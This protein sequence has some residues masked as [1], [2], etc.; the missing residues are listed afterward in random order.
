MPDGTNFLMTAFAYGTNEDYLVHVIAVLRIIKKKGMASDIKVTW[1][2]MV[3]VR[4]EMKPYFL[5]PEDE[6][7]AAKE[8]W[9]QMLSEYKEVI[10]AKENFAIAKTQKAYKMFCC[11]VVGNPRTQWDKIVHEM[12]TKDPWI[13][14]NESSN[15]GIRIRS[16]PSFLDCIKLHKL[17]IFPVDTAERQHYYM[18]QMVKK[19]QRA[20]VHQYMACMG[21][22]NDYISHLPMVFNSPMAVE[23]T[24]KG[25][26]PFDE[27]DLAGIVLNSVPVYWMNQYN[28]MH[29]TL[30][31]GTRTLLQD[32]ESIKCI[33]EEK[34]EAGQKAKAKEAAASAITKGRSNKRSSSG[35]P[36]EQV[37]KKGKPNK[38]CQH[39]KAKGGPHS[40]YNTKKCHRYDG[41]G[42]PV[43]AA[44]CKSGDAKPSS[45]K[46]GDKQMAYLTATVESLMKK[47]LKKAMKSKKHKGNR[48]YDS[49]SSSNSDSK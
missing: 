14:V 37:P 39:C 8:I 4:R 3:E 2:V 44:A 17:T 27:A 49:P 12:H 45:K 22:L 16:W 23:G 10:K 21:V 42:N 11:F 36:G 7:K 19:P 5:F 18:T 35:N 24:K 40:T 30:H 46:G 6:T 31:N 47:G 26:V 34:G 9:K 41:M 48:A 15:K 13:G 32:L 1:E 33:M 28:M 25:N 38:F 43:A 29:T 20:T